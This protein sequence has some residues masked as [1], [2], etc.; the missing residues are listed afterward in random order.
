MS[1]VCA[2]LIGTLL[3]SLPFST[4]SG[5]ISFVDALF[6]ATSAVCVTG[7]TVQDT[8]AYFSPVGHVIL[9]VLFQMG[10]LGIMAFSTLILLV[11]GKKISVKDRIIVQ[12][13]YTPSSIKNVKGLIRNIFA[14]TLIIE[15]L[16]TTFLYVHWCSQSPGP[17]TLFR[18]AFHCVSAFC[19]AGFSLSSESFVSCRGD[20]WVNIIIIGLIIAG[21]LGFLVLQ[22]IKGVFGSWVRRKKMHISLHTKLVLSL[23]VFL[24]IVPA[25][26]FFAIEGGRAMQDFGV[27]ERILASFFQAV[28]A[29]TAG[30]HTMDLNTLSVASV[31]LLILLMFIGASPGSTGGGVKTSTF[32]VIF[33]FLKSRV[34]ARESVSLYYRT[35][36]LE[37]ITKAF[38]V[39]TLS[40]GVIFLAVFVL[41]IVREGGTMEG[42]FF[43]VVSAF[44]TVGLSLG[45]TPVLTGFGKIILV[46]TMYIGRIGP[47]TLLYA[48]SRRRAYGKY[49]YAEESVM[50]G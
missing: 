43:E 33:A 29:R 14:Y 19:N 9:L 38:M 18:S 27:K 20:F 49:E 15:G 47:L 2:I 13:G 50:I 11:A 48:L 32:G 42:V 16:G 40:I 36:P 7:L 1:F 37:Q 25:L 44:G 17:R 46:F 8:A 5:Q 12:Q 45:I 21:G 30:F 22:E 41:L 35:L 6:T 10:G 4:Q 39:V 24:I 23:S 26:L 31:F 34:K 3:L 28:T